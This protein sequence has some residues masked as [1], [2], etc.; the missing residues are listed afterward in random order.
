MVI[1]IL[2][3]IAEICC[4]SLMLGSAVVIFYYLYSFVSLK[5]DSLKTVCVQFSIAPVLVVSASILAYLSLNKYTNF[6]PYSISTFVPFMIFGQIMIKMYSN[7]LSLSALSRMSIM[8]TCTTIYCISIFLNGVSFKSPI[9]AYIPTDNDIEKIKFFIQMFD[10]DV[11]LQTMVHLVSS[12]TLSTFLYYVSFR[13]A[14]KKIDLLN[15]PAIICFVYS[16]F[17]EFDNWNLILSVSFILLCLICLV[18]K[19][20]IDFISIEKNVVDKNILT[21]KMDIDKMVKQKELTQNDVRKLELIARYIKNNEVAI[22]IVV[23][24]KLEKK[25]RQIF[26]I[27]ED[28]LK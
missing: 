14:Y 5:T 28:N 15:L 16:T 2:F 18:L 17:F 13:T 12:V 11:N 20:I 23:P 9:I 1:A 7:S 22:N 27:L 3:A 24:K 26:K 4:I 21:F 8:V 10:F 6:L 25:N 19:T